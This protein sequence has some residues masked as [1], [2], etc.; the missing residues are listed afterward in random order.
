MKKI[1][2]ILFFCTATFIHAQISNGGFPIGYNQ[3]K[4]MDINFIDMP[5]IDNEKIH[6][7]YQNE[8]I[9]K[10]QPYRFGEKIKVNLGLNNSG[11]WTVL[12]NGDRVWNLG[13]RSKGAKSIN[14][15]FSEY[16][17]PIGAEVFIYNKN[18]TDFIGSFNN[19]N[20]KDHGNLP[21]L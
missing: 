15:I 3:S 16:N 19:S 12:E 13:I 9:K 17:L 14:L 4:K 8:E 11:I 5:S 2:F 21:L 18:K 10:N 7:L 20:N 1:L 6:L